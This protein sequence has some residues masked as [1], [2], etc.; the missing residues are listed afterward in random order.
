MSQNDWKISTNYLNGTPTEGVAEL[1][2]NRPNL[3]PE[4][5]NAGTYCRQWQIYG[6]T[7]TWG[8]L[9][10]RSKNPELIEIPDT[11]AV[12][13]RAWMQYS[14]T[15][16]RDTRCGLIARGIGDS[17]SVGG[18]SYHFSYRADNN[19]FDLDNTWY[20]APSGVDFNQ[21]DWFHMRLDVIP[22]K[23][24]GVTVMD[25]LRGFIEIDGEWSLV[26]EK[27]VEVTDSEYISPSSGKYYGVYHHYY[28]SY[29]R[30]YFFV[31]KIQIYTES[32]EQPD[33]V[34]IGLVNDT[35]VSST[36]RI[37]SDPT[38][39]VVSSVEDNSV[40]KYSTDSYNWQDGIPTPVSGANTVYVK[41][42]SYDGKASRPTKFEYLYAP[43]GPAF[44][45]E[46]TASAYQG[47]G[48][49]FLIYKTEASSVTDFSYDLKQVDDYAD[50][51][52]SSSS[53]LVYA[54]NNLDY[55]TKNSYN[56]T[57][58]ATDLAGN[59]TEKPVLLNV[60]EEDEHYYDT[61]LILKMDNDLS[62]SS[63]YEQD[64]TVSGVQLTG[65]TSKYGGSSAY[66]DG[67]TNTGLQIPS[68]G[69]LDLR[70]VEWTMEAWIKPDGNY[71]DHRMIIA[72]R[73]YSGTVDYH[74]YLSMNTG[75][76][77]FYNGT[78]GFG[79]GITPPANQWTHVAAVRKNG[80]IT[81]YIN[82]EAKASQ[83]L[84]IIYHQNL[85]LGIGNAGTLD[86]HPFRGHIDDVRITKGVARYTEDFLVPGPVPSTGGEAITASAITEG[87]YF[88]IDPSISA[89]YSG[90]FIYD[91]VNNNRTSY[92]H[93][94]TSIVSG[95]L[96][97][98]GSGD[99]LGFGSI[100]PLSTFTISVAVKPGTTQVDYADIFDNNHDSSRNFVLQQSATETNEYIFS[101]PGNV[102]TEYFYLDPNEWH[103]LTFCY[104]NTSGLMFYK[105]G[106]FVSSKHA[107]SINVSSHSLTIASHHSLGFGRY[108]NG[109][110]GFFKIYNKPLS[111]V[112]VK[113]D[114]EANKARFGLT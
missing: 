101:V 27:Y 54:N 80:I 111:L 7:T 51:S 82:G 10:I 1:H 18:G 114:Y 108:W 43:E 50:F 73:S 100:M 56:F 22:I 103:I 47:A 83:T 29:S 76:L 102:G 20:V 26:A 90:S 39:S 44:S 66:F 81:L 3:I 23:L 32:I 75:V 53:G 106:E 99:Y 95:N 97:F 72:K 71:D 58:T 112:E 24:N 42:V 59:T 88:N 2:S 45:S 113:Q 69:L 8:G 9:F 85:P 63:V 40:V 74:L 86:R 38:L 33:N 19:T 70:N 98:D 34:Y 61:S 41:Q 4:S 55:A 84:D 109:E 5:A 52:I 37:T 12:S 104:S 96:D 87:L 107:G 48:S 64:V 21:G 60:L 105:N 13:I 6:S 68:S 17:W 79:S 28:T 36:D 30:S 94:D 49:D 35:G 25:H 89:S 67:G 57:V 92:L 16:T 110:M 93:G 14:Y 62:C 46:A 31:D 91:T 77:T 11:K 78:T 65:S 15:A